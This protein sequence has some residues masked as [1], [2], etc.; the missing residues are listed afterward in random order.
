VKLVVTQSRFHMEKCVGCKTCTHVCP[1]MAYVPSSTRPLDQKKIAPCSLRCPVGN[2]IEGFLFLVGQKKYLDAYHLLLK[3]NPFPGVTG[4]VC[5]HPCEQDCN[6]VKFDQG[7][8]IQALERFVADRAMRGG[9]RPVKLKAGQ[10]AKVAIVG[11]GP[12][13]LSC[14]YHLARWGYRTTVFEAQ[15]RLGGMLRYGIPE[16]RLPDNIL[17]WEIKNITSL[18][19]QVRLRQRLGTNLRFRDLDQ[20]DALFIATGSQKSR[21]LSIP[22]EEAR[23]V[24]SALEFLKEVNS[25][26][27]VHLSKRIAVI[28]G[29]NSALDAARCALRLGAEPLILYRRSIEEMPALPHEREALQ[30]EGI[31]ILPLVIPVRILTEEDRIRGIECLRARLGEPGKDGRRVPIPVKG[32]TFHIEV[33]QVIVAAGE[34]PELSGFTRSL[35]IKGDRIV[36][37][38]NGATPRERTFAGGDV[39]TGSGTVSEAIASGK[40]G[41]MAIHRFLLRDAI[42][43]NG[44]E[45]EV[46][47]FEE[48]N[49]D[50]FPSGEKVP[51][52]SLDPATAVLS[53][54]EVSSGYEEFEAVREARRCFGCAAPPTYHLEDCRGCTNCE[55]RCPASAITIEPREKPYTVGVNPNEFPPDLI[56]TLCK[57]A[58]VHPQQVICYCTNTTAGEIAAA[59]LRGADTP[60]AISRLTGARTGCT[61]LCIQSIARILEASGHPG[62]S[63]ETHQSYGKTFTLWDLDTQTKE[64]YETVGYHFEEDRKLIDKVFEEDEGRAKPWEKIP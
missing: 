10:K 39:A 21:E 20:F 40:K 43:G 16:Y 31:R 60:E 24:L 4:R 30:A 35:K 18:H 36:T 59:I 28:G 57:N 48:L 26:K 38:T 1:T 45:P 41:A 46:V 22:G 47:R 33:D 55:Q 56:F 15:D 27:R 62:K 9:Y 61:V 5:H 23:G 13:G 2:D 17:E 49:P 7:L 29:G 6:R 53:F 44:V 8:S 19:V 12:A 11:S 50:Y 3:S 51:L 64:K 34:S 32:S 63:R 37:G 42:E 52:R 58:N 14:A 25:G 54:D